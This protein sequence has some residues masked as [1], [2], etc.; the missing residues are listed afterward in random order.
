MRTTRSALFPSG[1]LS[2][3]R[4]FGTALASVGLRGRAVLG[5]QLEQ[6]A[7]RYS[8]LLGPDGAA[9]ISAVKLTRA[10]S[11]HL[12][13]LRAEPPVLARINRAILELGAR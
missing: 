8:L 12:A 5:L 1:I 2:P 9:S 13:E 11:R 6:K 7:I 10:Q 3:A 4:Q